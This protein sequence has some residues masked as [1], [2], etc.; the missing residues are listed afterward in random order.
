MTR[1]ASG[2]TMCILGVGWLLLGAWSLSTR[3]SLVG[4]G[5]CTLG[6]HDSA[7]ASHLGDVTTSADDPPT[8]NAETLGPQDPA[9]TTRLLRNDPRTSVAIARAPSPR[10]AVDA[11]ITT[12]PV[13]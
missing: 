1:A 8:Q 2:T 11:V 9:D 13:R 6:S 7:S 10:A 12:T 4:V 3:N 5:F